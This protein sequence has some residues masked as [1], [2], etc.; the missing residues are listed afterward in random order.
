MVWFADGSKMLVLSFVCREGAGINCL[1]EHTLLKEYK[2]VC[3]VD[4]LNVYFNIFLIKFKPIFFPFINS[5]IA[6]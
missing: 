4:E 1:V 2:H 3:S 5:V 6:G